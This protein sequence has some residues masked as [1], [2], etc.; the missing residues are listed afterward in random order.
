MTGSRYPHK[1][2][3]REY[4]I[5][6]K[7]YGQSMLLAYNMSKHSVKSLISILPRQLEKY[8][9]FDFF[10]IAWSSFR[11]LLRPSKNTALENGRF[12][13]YDAE[14]SSYYGILVYW[15]PLSGTLGGILLKGFPDTLS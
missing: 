6:V 7:N 9:M 10:F 14:Q 2:L 8:F 1:Y 3:V 15:D 12:C 13:G 11:Q 4:T 5:D